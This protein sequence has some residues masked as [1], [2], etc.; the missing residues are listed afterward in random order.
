MIIQLRVAMLSL[1]ISEINHVRAAEP[2]QTGSVL[3]LLREGIAPS[4]PGDQF[5]SDLELELTLRDGKFDPKVWGYSMSFNKVFH[6]GNI[7]SMT[8]MTRERVDDS[9]RRERIMNQE[10]CSSTAVVAFSR[11]PKE[12]TNMEKE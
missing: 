7:S 5:T 6:D 10:P 9:G 3:L 11:P 12:K 4:K 1:L 8:C 2:A